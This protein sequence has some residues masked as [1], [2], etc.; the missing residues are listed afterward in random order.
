[1]E[2]LAAKTAIAVWLEFLRRCPDTAD[3]L[4]AA[5]A[6]PAPAVPTWSIC[7][8]PADVVARRYSSLA[9]FEL[10]VSGF[11]R[12]DVYVLN[13]PTSQ[14]RSIMEFDPWFSY[15]T[16][17][18]FCRPWEE[19]ALLY[20]G[21][22]G[23]RHGPDPEDPKDEHRRRYH[24]QYF[25]LVDALDYLEPRLANHQWTVAEPGRESTLELHSLLG[26]GWQ[27][28]EELDGE[29]GA[30]PGSA[31]SVPLAEALFH[32][33]R[34]GC[35]GASSAAASILTAINIPAGS[36]VTDYG[37]E[38][39]HTRPTFELL[40]SPGH[41]QALT[42]LHGDDLGSASLAYLPM[43]RRL[44][45]EEQ[46]RNLEWFRV[47]PN[48]VPP[49]QRQS[50]P[51]HKDDPT[52]GLSEALGHSYEYEWWSSPGED[53]GVGPPFRLGTLR[54][55]L[56]VWITAHRAFYLPASSA[57]G[58]AWDGQ[59]RLPSEPRDR[60][61]GVLPDM[62]AGLAQTCVGAGPEAEPIW[63]RFPASGE[64]YPGSGE[65]Y[66]RRLQWWFWVV[67]TELNERELQ[68]SGVPTRDMPQWL[69]VLEACFRRFPGDPEQN[70]LLHVW[71]GRHRVHW[72]PELDAPELA[73]ICGP[74][75][76]GV[77]LD[78]WTAAGIG[79]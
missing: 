65:L 78:H 18:A 39:G 77:S 76:D 60:E 51:S 32:R 17:A 6:C 33:V 79:R 58:L 42:L 16:A 2:I 44:Q 10:D 24:A 37:G 8:Y 29:G 46:E 59:H 63:E 9:F 20:G 19:R 73:G 43:A 47:P 61:V 57:R 35:K 55:L 50:I 74:P 56:R 49:N 69:A 72:V 71:E 7:D 75:L 62:P 1:M 30:Y 3:R 22:L 23:V 66:G 40:M 52:E 12:D 68:R 5:G 67:W 45:T 15:Q 64:D 13:H 54:R 27:R 21:P 70:W 14:R 28:S 26:S 53:Y 4:V 48:R 34:M 31:I 11:F 25:T 41:V 36:T 38:Y